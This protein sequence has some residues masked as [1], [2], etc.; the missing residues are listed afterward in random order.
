MLSVSRWWL[1]A[2]QPYSPE[3]INSMFQQLAL[4]GVEKL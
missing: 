2:E 1:E 3:E 4:T